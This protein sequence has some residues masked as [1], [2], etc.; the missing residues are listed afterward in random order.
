MSLSLV[1][2][3]RDSLFLGTT[4]HPDHQSLSVHHARWSCLRGMGQNLPGLFA[5]AALRRRSHSSCEQQT[6]RC[7]GLEEAVNQAGV[8]QIMN[9]LIGMMK[10][11]QDI[12][13]RTRRSR[14]PWVF[15]FR[16]QKQG[17]WVNVRLRDR[18]GRYA[19]RAHTESRQ[20]DRQI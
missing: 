12:Y 10:R 1:F 2:C 20:L 3:L 16:G 15:L 18:E 5:T 11:E 4:C 8:S 19:D 6:L 17:W 14:S 9:N 13:P 7:R